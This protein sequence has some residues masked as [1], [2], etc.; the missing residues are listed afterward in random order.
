MHRVVHLGFF[1]TLECWNYVK[2]T[3]VSFRDLVPHN[4]QRAPPSKLT[5]RGKKVLQFMG[6]STFSEYSVVNQIAVAK[7]HP[8][9]P[10]DKVCLLGCGISTGYGAAVNTAK[11]WLCWSTAV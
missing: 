8:E 6:I 5:C 7:I 10:L 1:Q 4:V 2:N 9:A 11:V 3:I